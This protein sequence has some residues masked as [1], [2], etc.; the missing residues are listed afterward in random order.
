MFW[1]NLLVVLPVGW[2]I[3]RSIGLRHASGST[4]PSPG[5]RQMLRRIFFVLWY[6]NSLGLPGEGKY[7]CR[8]CM[9]FVMR[10]K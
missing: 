2:G 4:Q 6:E 9:K 8:K 7:D 1:Q 5:A 10:L 3:I